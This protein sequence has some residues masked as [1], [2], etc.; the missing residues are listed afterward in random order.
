M[1]VKLEKKS[2]ALLKAMLGKNYRYESVGIIANA[3]LVIFYAAERMRAF[4]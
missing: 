2:E 3:S 4:L 1:N